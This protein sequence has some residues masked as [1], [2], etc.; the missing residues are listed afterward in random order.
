M[1]VIV[2]S[3]PSNE[4]GITRA[5]S[6]LGPNVTVLNKK[7][8]VFTGSLR[9]CLRERERTLVVGEDWYPSLLS[10]VLLSVL[11]PRKRIGPSD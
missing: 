7:Y 11:I 10:R 3:N 5:L 8:F 9:G 2:D 6:F 1:M 4:I